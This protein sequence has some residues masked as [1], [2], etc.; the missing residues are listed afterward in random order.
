MGATL[1]RHEIDRRK[2]V[3]LGQLRFFAYSTPSVHRQV[4]HAPPILPAVT[5]NGAQT[6]LRDG[7]GTDRLV[8]S[9]MS[10][11]NGVEIFGRVSASARFVTSDENRS[12]QSSDLGPSAGDIT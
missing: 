11:E 8:W 9:I 6:S 7:I 1:T 4:A 12:R 3:N 10:V 5:A 2:P